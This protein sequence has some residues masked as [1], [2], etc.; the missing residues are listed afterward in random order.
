VFA[1]SSKC[2]VE[3]VLVLSCNAVLGVPVWGSLLRD[4]IGFPPHLPVQ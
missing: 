2:A 1:L 3:M 4:E